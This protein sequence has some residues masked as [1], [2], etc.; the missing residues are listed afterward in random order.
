MHLKIFSWQLSSDHT[1]LFTHKSIDYLMQAHGLEIIASWHF[2]TD[3]LDLRRSLLVTVA[4]NDSS[5]SLLNVISTEFLNTS[6][7]MSFNLS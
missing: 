2:G 6:L 3:I 5:N 7:L 1:H 4:Q